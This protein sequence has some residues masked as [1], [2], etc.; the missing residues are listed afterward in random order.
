MIELDND[1]L[2]AQFKQLIDELLHGRLNRTKFR[3]WEIEILVDI[4]SCNLPMASQCVNILRQYQNA[5]Q[6]RIREGAQVPLKLSEYLEL[7]AKGK[8]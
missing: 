8:T 2:L 1:A 6:Q 4:V 5:V 7:K 3:P